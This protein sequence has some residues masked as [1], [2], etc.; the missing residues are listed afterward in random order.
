MKNEFEN[1]LDGIDKY[2]GSFEQDELGVTQIPTTTIQLLN[3]FTLLGLFTFLASCP[4][5]WKMNAKFL[6]KHF[7]CNK[8]KIYAAIDG[9]IEFRLLTRK[10]IRD[11]GKF[12]RYHYR[13]HLRQIAQPTPCL[14]K[15]DT[16]KPDTENPDTYKTLLPLKNKK[17]ITTTTVNS[18]ANAQKSSA[19]V[20]IDIA[21]N[22]HRS[23]SFFSEK[24]KNELLTFKHPADNRTEEKFLEHCQHHFEIQPKDLSRYQR[25]TGLKNLL[26]KLC[27]HD[28]H[29]QAKGFNEINEFKILESRTPT[30]EEF[31]QWKSGVSGTEWIGAW[32]QRQI[33][34]KG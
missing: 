2:S 21:V 26:R 27:D 5:N 20:I 3:D 13:L 16:V 29:F 32:R 4:P 31:N 1:D 25:L 34:N 17:F 18:A 9:L 30:E 28:E 11:K 12:V 7:K 6:A 23:N 10:Q 8:D 19:N 24:Q 15:P 22:Q 14:E 33:Q